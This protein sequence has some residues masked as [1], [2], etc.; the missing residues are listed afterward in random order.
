MRRH[1]GQ[2]HLEYRPGGFLW[3]RRYPTALR[4]D[5]PTALRFGL[6]THDPVTARDLAARITRL[7]D[8]AFEF[9]RVSPMQH[10]DFH[11]VITE[12]VR[13]KL[14]EEDLRRARGEMRTPSQAAQ[15]QRE[16]S[17]ACETM[18]HAIALRD[19]SIVQDPIRHMLDQLGYSV[20][21]GS[22]AWRELGHETARALIDTT[23][24]IARRDRGEF[25]EP[26]VYFRSARGGDRAVSVRPGPAQLTPVA[27]DILSAPARPEFEVSEN[28]APVS[29][30]AHE[31]R[32]ANGKRP[33]A[34]N[35]KCNIRKGTF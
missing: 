28:P 7:T 1:T 26:S 20:E 5:P 32:K 6:H 35:P 25:D 17:A 18:R 2:P 22:A 12:L 19:Y 27:Q 9:A 13:W 16:L 30:K 33:F 3:R 15:R 10:A 8:L 31:I 34:Q 24:E 21:E 14:R 11:H 23:E 29:A 4:F